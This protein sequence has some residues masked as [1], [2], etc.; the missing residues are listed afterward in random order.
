LILFFGTCLTIS[1]ILVRGGAVHPK[2]TA[3]RTSMVLQE[4]DEAG[5]AAPAR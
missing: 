4:D 2:K 3:V 1:T 5:V